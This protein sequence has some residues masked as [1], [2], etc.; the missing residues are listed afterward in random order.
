MNVYK[1]HKFIYKNLDIRM[2]RTFYKYQP[3]FRVWKNVVVSFWCRIQY[4]KKFFSILKFKVKF[5]VNFAADSSH[6][7][8]RRLKV[9]KMNSFISLRS[10]VLVYR[11]R[12]RIH[13]YKTDIIIRILLFPWNLQY[14]KYMT[15][16]DSIPKHI[17][18]YIRYASRQMYSRLCLLTMHAPDFRWEC[19]ADFAH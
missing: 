3:S 19:R 12:E 8:N 15:W 4:K 18:V 9:N 10:N 6:V 1:C 14:R 16:L 7:S 13:S 5:K 11:L 2:N 17:H